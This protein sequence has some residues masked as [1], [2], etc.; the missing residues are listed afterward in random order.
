MLIAAMTEDGGFAGVYS[1][2][3][4][5]FDTKTVREVVEFLSDDEDGEE[6]D[7][8]L[9]MMSGQFLHHTVWSST[10]F[11]YVLYDAGQKLFII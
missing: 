1:V 2:G 3:S 11:P 9:I 6:Q 4:E 8:D 7:V 5:T 10:K